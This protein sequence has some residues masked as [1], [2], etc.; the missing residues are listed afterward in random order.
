M[1]NQLAVP[2]YRQ[3]S[4]CLDSRG[5]QLMSFWIVARRTL[6]YLRNLRDCEQR[7]SG[8]DEKLD[9]VAFGLCSLLFLWLP[10]RFRVK[11]LIYLPFAKRGVD[12]VNGNVGFGQ[13]DE[14][15]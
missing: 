4:L 6:I 12:S 13:P 11:V 7:F 3:R 9:G 1:E 8:S 2:G 15:I 14:S 10:G 5:F